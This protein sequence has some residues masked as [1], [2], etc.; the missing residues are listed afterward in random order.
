MR[1]DISFNSEGF[2]CAGWLYLPDDLRPGQKVPGIVMANAISAVKEITLPGYAA[3]FAAVGYAVLVF[4]YRH[5]GSSEGAPRNHLDPHEQQQDIRN[6][7]TWLRAQPE[8]D[9]DRIGGWGISLGGVHMLHL[10]A[11]DRRLKAIVSVATGLNTLETMMGRP[12]LQSFLRILNA[13]RD[14]RL[15]SGQS[16]SYMPAVS[17]PGKGG[18]MA[19]PEANDFYTNAMNSYAPTYENRITTASVENLIADHSDAAVHLIT[20]TALLMIHGEKDLIPPDAV[21]C[22]F[23][24][25][26]EPK[27]LV[28]LDCLHTDLY[29]REPWVTQSADEAIAWF[30]RYLH[31]PRGKTPVPQDAERNKQ[32]VLDFYARSF[33]GDLEVYDELFSEDFTSFSSAT[34]GE[35]R[36]REAFRAAYLMYNQAFPDFTSTLDIVVAENNLVFVY[37]ISTGTHLGEFMFL[38]PTGKSL[39]W[40]GAA[41]YRFNDEGLIDGRWQEFN[42]LSLF[43]QLGLI[44]GAATAAG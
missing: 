14:K 6:A 37:G 25:A 22:V 31:N 23:D 7:I 2:Q 3:R 34:G 8:V 27:K 1:R 10:G 15:G 16:A 12:G 29:T 20:P 24:R 38:P 41:I 11:Y 5:Y 18:L 43:Q 30:D 33:K 13:D 36:G 9:P 32:I 39:R 21:R 28:V 44:P 17:M 4:D 26:C 42:G 19:F 40:S 35:L